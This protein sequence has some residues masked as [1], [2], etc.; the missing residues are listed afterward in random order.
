MN[1]AHSSIFAGEG[2]ARKA[3]R[4]VDWAKTPLG[5]PE[6]WPTSIRTTVRML[7]SSRHPMFLWWGPELIQTYNDAYIPSFGHGKHPAAMGQRGAD[8]WQEI[9]PIIHPQIEDVVE[10]ARASWNENQLV[11]IYRNGRIEEVYWTYGYSPVFD[12]SGGVGGVLVVC[13][14]TTSGVLAV[15]RLGFLRTLANALSEAQE[16]E[17]VARIGA[18]CLTEAP[19]DIPFGVIAVDGTAPRQL[20]LDGPIPGLL[21]EARDPAP[22][23]RRTLTPGIVC[24][25]WQEPVTEVAMHSFDGAPGGVITFG[26]SPRLPFDE[27]YRSFL[28]QVVE[29]ISIALARV[30]VERA[31]DEFLAMLGHEL[32]NPLAPILT[33]LEVMK[34][35]DPKGLEQERRIVERQ[36]S[37]LV[38]LVDDLLDVSRVAAG[39][40]E[41]KKRRVALAEVVATAIETASP[42]LEKKRQRLRVDVPTV[43]LDVDVDPMRLGQVVS[44][45]LTNAARYTGDGGTV[46]IHARHAD[47]DIVLRVEDTGI[48]IP[49][50]QIPR[51]F[52]RFFQ[53]ARHGGDAQGGLGLGLALVKGLTELHGGSVHAESS[54]LGK[55]SAFELRLALASGDAPAEAASAETYTKR[56]DSAERVL[57]IDDSEDI[58]ELVSAFLEHSGFDVRTAPDGPSALRIAQS[59]KP[60]VA[61]LDLGLPVMDG[62]E[63]AAKLLEQLGESAPRL[64]A[65]SG[66]GQPEDIE[67]TNRAGFERHL[68]KPVDGAS[69]LRAIAGE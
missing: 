12:E 17:D 41:L 48:G 69:L 37:H 11:P 16:S 10:R 59:F 51:L 39:K 3:G 56:G 33:A 24:Q 19:L 42:L 22:F 25:A 15:R 66:Y 44:N 30:A 32:R 67:R 55:G 9:W 2:A 27:A 4:A 60:T 35:K 13:T 65:M 26:I 31:K 1:G 58:T 5:P 57:L 45:L 50:E 46:S 18:A 7:L 6:N 47:G 40:I 8:C 43:G 63:V 52:E 54:G 29:Q 21:S 14:E 61:V 36:A 68:V 20:G 53:G 62:Y 49:P 28:Q 34:I 64:I 38:H 23:A